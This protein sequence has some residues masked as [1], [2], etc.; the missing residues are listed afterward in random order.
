MTHVPSRLISVIGAK[1]II[2]TV[3]SGENLETIFIAV[4]AI[5]A[6]FVISFA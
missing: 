5:A 3:E 1:Y 2:D 6:V 4:G